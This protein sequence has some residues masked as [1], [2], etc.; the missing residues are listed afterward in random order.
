M[1]TRKAKA[2][3]AKQDAGVLRLVKNEQ[4]NSKAKSKTS[5]TAIASWLGDVLHPTLRKVREGWGTRKISPLR[6]GMTNK[7]AEA[8]PLRG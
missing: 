2:K 4:Q 8:D 1:T 6:C 5:T 3:G 7:K